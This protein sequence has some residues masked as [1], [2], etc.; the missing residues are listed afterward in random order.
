MEIIFLLDEIVKK[1][2]FEWGFLIK[3]T[4]K[5]WKFSGGLPAAEKKPIVFFPAEK[6]P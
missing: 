6:N 4:W 1:H 2:Y 3:P 5:G